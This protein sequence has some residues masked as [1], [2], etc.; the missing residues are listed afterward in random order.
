MN[1]ELPTITDDN[2]KVFVL[3]DVKAF[4][5][6]LRDFHGAE[7]TLHTEPGGY[8]FTVTDKL[9]RQVDELAAQAD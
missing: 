9:R 8:M 4:Q 5:Q 1:A 6:H 7:G 3:E 2:G